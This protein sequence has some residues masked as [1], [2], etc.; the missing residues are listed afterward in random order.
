MP[1][2]IPVPLMRSKLFVPAIRPDLFPKAL[3]SEAD[4]ICFDLEDS[5]PA[6]RKQ[7]A[8]KLLADFLQ[9]INSSSHPLL[10]VRTNPASSPDFPLD[11]VTAVQ[12]SVS[13]IALPKTENVP[14]VQLADGLVGKIEREQELE[15]AIGLLLTIESPRGLRLAFELANCSP[16]IVGLQLGFADLLEPLGI[17]STDSSA[18]S[19]LRLMLRLAAAEADLDCYESAYPNFRDESGFL[20][21]LQDARSLGFAGASCI[22]PSQISP[23][24]KIFSPTPEEMA[25]AAGVIDAA[26]QAA[27]EGKAVSVFHGKMIDPPLLGRA[28]KIVSQ[29]LT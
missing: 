29:N 14:D 15:H 11:L 21:Q 8:R 20:A 19:Q 28:R 16:R 5:V 26:E 7:E 9:G 27:R 6:D 13:V 1:S 25:Y 4:A 12:R 24:N 17:S 3:A 23:S 2:D 18:R 10:A 22:H